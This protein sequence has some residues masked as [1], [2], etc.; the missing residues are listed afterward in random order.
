MLATP[1]NLVIDHRGDLTL[2]A[3]FEQLATD[4]QLLHELAMPVKVNEVSAGNDI[5]ANEYF[6]R[7]DWL[8]LY[9]NT[10]QPIDAAGLYVSDDLD[11][12]LKFQIP[13]SSLLNTVIPAG[14]HLILWADKL[15]SQ[16]Q[17]HANFKL[18]N[19]DGQMV[20]VS[21][22]DAFVANNSSYFNRHP[23]MQ[24]FV[25]GL[26]YNAH[27]GDESVGR[28]PDG[29]ADFY[30]MTRPTIERANRVLTS[31]SLIGH[32]QDLMQTHTAPFQLQL[33]KGWNWT[34]HILQT[35]IAVDELSSHA[36]RIVG[37]QY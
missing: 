27:H 37:Q 10:D 19:D 24:S 9:N 4:S 26:A 33:A 31:D 16:S 32:D 29:G 13:Q 36:E 17:I 12:P 22:S 35:P 6:K 5:Y 34:S 20:V 30:L 14:G 8:E 23:G 15:E 25:D 1:P 2:T 21:S 18:G 28:F 11:E 7:N 3:V